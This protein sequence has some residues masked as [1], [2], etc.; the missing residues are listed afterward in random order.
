MR[1]QYKHLQFQ[2]YPVP[3]LSSHSFETSLRVKQ[4]RQAYEGSIQVCRLSP[5]PQR[6]IKG[7]HNPYHSLRT[8]LR[9]QNGYLGSETN[10]TVIT[11]V[12]YPEPSSLHAKL[13]LWQQVAFN[14][15]QLCLSP[16]WSVSQEDPTYLHRNLA[17]FRNARP[18]FT[19]I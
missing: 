7:P 13:P 18:G 5:R 6:V 4:P 19:V 1:I 16:S 9:I 17:R 14:A 10:C 8:R 2:V 3:S 11:P 15:I 12:A